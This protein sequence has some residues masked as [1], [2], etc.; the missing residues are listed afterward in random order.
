MPACPLHLTKNVSLCYLGENT[1]DDLGKQYNGL[2]SPGDGQP[3]RK[4]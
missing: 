2:F 1:S 4:G 3:L